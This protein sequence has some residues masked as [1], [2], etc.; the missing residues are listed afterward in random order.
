MLGPKG[1]RSHVYDKADFEEA[2]RRAGGIE[3]WIEGQLKGT[4]VTVVLFGAEAYDRKWVR[5]EIKRSYELKKGLLAID[6]HKVKEPK[7]G[8]DV[9]GPNPLDCWNIKRNGTKV[10]FSDIF[11]TYDWIDDRGYHNIATW[12]EKAAKAAGR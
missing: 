7:H 9:S 11:N 12:I 3:R 8:P 6:I 2:K 1:R 5:H 10:P 4:S